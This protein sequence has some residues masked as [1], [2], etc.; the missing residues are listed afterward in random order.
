[1]YPNNNYTKPRN[2]SISYL[3]FNKI[4]SRY[5]YSILDIIFN[6]CKEAK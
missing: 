6:K 4:N 3:F 2:T 5:L 1:M